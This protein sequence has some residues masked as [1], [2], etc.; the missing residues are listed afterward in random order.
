MH[1]ISVVVTNY[2]YGHLLGRCIRSLLNQ[3]LEKKLYE[4]IVIDDGSGDDSLNILDVFANDIRI[5]S[6]KK[7]MGLAYASNIGIKS[8]TSRYFVRVDSDDYVHPK[9]LENLLLGFELLGANFEAISCD[10][11]RVEEDGKIIELGSQ[12]RN[13]I[14][15]AIAFKI[16][17]FEKLGFYND[18]LRINE[19]VDFMAR[20]QEAGF[21]IYNINLPLYRYVQHDNSL[22]RRVPR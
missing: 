18:T 15:C 4:V 1:E 10:Y 3:T 22:T 14:A 2:N 20:F 6:L 19:E 13:P 21:N 11:F 12:I 16:D 17:A 7:N 9:F 5:I 8:C